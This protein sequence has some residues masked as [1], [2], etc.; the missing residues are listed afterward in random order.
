[1]VV[2]VTLF[3][4]PSVYTLEKTSYIMEISVHNQCIVHLWRDVW[5]AVTSNYYA[6][7][8]HLQEIGAL[9]P[10]NEKHLICLHYVMVP[11]LNVDLDLFYEP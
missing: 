9:D 3:S 7:F 11:R 6:A 5:C 4:F 1:M 10:D 2:T 8:Q